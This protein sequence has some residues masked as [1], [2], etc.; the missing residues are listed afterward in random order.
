M[1]KSILVWGA[2]YRVTH[3]EDHAA[4]FTESGNNYGNL[5]IGHGVRSVLEH[6]PLLDREDLASPEEANERCSQ[7]VVPAANF[8]WKDFDFAYM[9]NFLE[10]TRLP[11]TM[12]GVGAQTNDRTTSSPI[13]PNTLRLMKLVSE[14]SAQIG[15]RGYY[16]AEVLAANGIHNV[17]VIGCPSLYSKRTPTIRVEAERLGRI[18]QLAVNLSRRV[19]RHSFHPDRMQAL[20]NKVLT[21]ALGKK[22]T[23]I[24]QDELDE[25]QAAF[26]QKPCPPQVTSYFNETEGAAVSRF[27]CEHTR[28][29][30]DI[31]AWSSFIRTQDAS[32]GTRFHGNLIALIN[33]V[34]ALMIIHDSRTMEMCTLMGIPSI[35]VSEIGP[36]GMST[37][38]LMERLLGARFDRFEA[39][40]AALYRRYLGFLDANALPHSLMRV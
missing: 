35:H 18:E 29:F 28:Y 15:V 26:S 6:V 23:F 38:Q 17:T 8:L 10:K 31:E 2:P 4:A 30:A 40:Y 36:E 7:V 21:L 20:E 37:E 34:P 32:I 14:R 24:A 13:H 39:A 25:L 1:S 22:S 19:N 16:T 9:L 12:I 11:V 3:P 27:F 5:L 33:G